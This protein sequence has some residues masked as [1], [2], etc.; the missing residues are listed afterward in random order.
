ME[1]PLELV[2]GKSALLVGVM[3]VPLTVLGHV[4]PPS[5][6]RVLWKSHL[7]GGELKLVAFLLRVRLL[8]ATVLSNGFNHGI[9]HNYSPAVQ[10]AVIKHTV[11]DSILEDVCGVVIRVSTLFRFEGK[12]CLDVSLLLFQLFHLLG[13]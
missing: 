9:R 10:V 2:V 11:V 3:G 4:A 6:T 12:H 7:E 5:D 1:R 13:N 8:K